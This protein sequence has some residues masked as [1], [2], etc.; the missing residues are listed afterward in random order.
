MKKV[1]FLSLGLVIIS[2]GIILRPITIPTQTKWIFYDRNGETLYSENYSPLTKEDIKA[3]TP[4]LLAVEDQRFYNHFGI[5][6]QAVL[7]AFKQN[8][9]AGKTVSGGS[10]LT[11][12][13]ARQLYLTEAKRDHWYKIQQAILALRLELYY[14]KEEI[15]KAYLQ[16]VYLGAPKKGFAA[17]A[18][19]YYSKPLASLSEAEKATLI[20]ILPR[21]QEWNP[22]ANPKKAE[23]RKNIVLQTWENQELLTTEEREYWKE[24]SVEL[25]LENENSITAPH[26]IFWVKK[27]LEDNV[28]KNTK[29]IHVHTT[30][31]K[32]WYQRILEIARKIVPDTNHKNMTNTS[33]M[34]L[35]KNSEIRT[36]LGSLDFFN[37][38]IQGGVNI[39]TSSREMG[40]TLKP[41]LF[42]FALQQ[43]ASPLETV[44]DQRQSFPTGQGSYSPRNYDIEKEY[45]PVRFREALAGSYNIGAVDLLN[46]LGVEPFYDFL[47]Q[48]GFRI[49][50]TPEQV[51]LALILG[52]GESRLLDLARGFSIFTHQGKLNEVRFFTKVTDENKKVILS[53]DTFFGPAKQV[54]KNHVAEWVLHALS[55]NAERWTNFSPGN[56]LELDFPVAVKTGT[57]QDFRDNYVVGASSDYTVAVWAGNTDGTPMR[58]SSGLQGAGPL[59]HT[60][61]R[62]LHP[63]KAPDFTWSSGRNEQTVCRWAWEEFPECSEKMTEFLLPSDQKPIQQKPQISIAFPGNGD[64]FHPD[65][66]ITIKVRNNQGPFKIFVDDQETNGLI[67]NL[68]VGSHTI[69][70]EQGN[71]QDTIAI[72]VENH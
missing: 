4:N 25:S 49:K 46:T 44:N 52:S 41:F 61:M 51:G 59:W 12:Q 57:S 71:Q 40:S 48:A 42:A 6:L 60:I 67:K 68:S 54:I 72:S 56:A 9:Q 19:Y 33:I 2:L 22:V 14:S 1:L 32:D 18:H 27:Q 31:D 29:E 55:D 11:M 50:K 63:Q 64:I 21:P 39:A 3:I 58:A 53:A 30:L 37:E 23:E 65:S 34:I 70:V 17:A 10:T 8:Y 15:L 7:R 35:D 62:F 45:G 69:R 43:G 16:Q 66:S 36:M 47:T 28:P 38:D 26:F 24:Q 5:D 20:G 13:L